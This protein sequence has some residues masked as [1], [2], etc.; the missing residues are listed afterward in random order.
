MQ[1]NANPVAAVKAILAAGAVGCV[2][3]VGGCSTV[4]ET[5]T[6]TSDAYSPKT[7]SV[8]DTSTGEKVW[9]CDVPVGQKLELRF[10]KRVRQAEETGSD[11]LSW[12][13]SGVDS[14]STGRKSTVK[15]PPISH[16]R[17]D[18]TLRPAPEA[19]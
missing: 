3:A 2:L 15:V 1:F 7:V 10:A 8:I 11:E 18:M 4:A 17:I 6:Y 13:L 19:R 9:T 5:Y 16:R 12:T 14:S